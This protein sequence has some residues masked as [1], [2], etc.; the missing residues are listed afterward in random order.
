MKV[1]SQE[2]KLYRYW[3]LHDGAWY[4]NVA[5]TYGFETANKLNKESLRSMAKRTMQTY[6]RERGLDSSTMDLATLVHHFME[7][8][9]E[10]WPDEWVDLESH[11][12]GPDSFEVVLKKNFA[13]EMLRKAGTLEK[14]ECTGLVLREGWFAGL[15]VKNYVQEEKECMVKGDPVCRFLV[16]IL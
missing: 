12:L 1:T 15:G 16:R 14:Y 5:K 8:A 4:Q 10:M 2:E 6:V 11:I 13:I 3:W 7:G 9:G